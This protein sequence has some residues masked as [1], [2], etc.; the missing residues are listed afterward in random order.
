[1]N[2]DNPFEFDF[3]AIPR[4]V[5]PLIFMV[6]TSS[7][8]GGAKIAALNTAIR[9]LLNEVSE[10]S[11]N[12]CDT[13]I[14]VAAL[15]FSSNARWMYPKLADSESFVWQDLQAG[16]LRSLGAAISELNDKLFRFYGFLSEA[17]GYCAPVIILFSDGEPTDDY[18]H[19]LEKI[20]NN[21]WFKAAL[22]IAIAIG[23][24][25]NIDI[26]AEFTGNIEA[27]ITVH[28]ISI[29]SKVIYGMVHNA[30]KVIYGM[31]HNVE[32]DCDAETEPIQSIVDDIRFEVIDITDST[33]AFDT[34]NGK[35]NDT[36]QNVSKVLNELIIALN[37][38]VEVL[39]YS[40]K[41]D[42][43]KIDPDPDSWDSW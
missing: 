10:I 24:D 26:L 31:V 6:G 41:N 1:M 18:K 8:M 21:Q 23:D 32:E 38:L 2:K 15:E 39:D 19:V 42:E 35:K 12:N 36:I 9:E 22:K 40:N 29:L 4:R 34:K 30:E 43:S 7:S 3:E 27:V 16:G 20:K 14:K 28:D 25:A 11:K 17:R 13:Q 5:M 37:K 33:K